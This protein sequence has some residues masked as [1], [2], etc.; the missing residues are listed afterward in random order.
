MIV[1][2]GWERIHVQQFKQ[3]RKVAVFLWLR[4]RQ[5]TVSFIIFAC[6]SPLSLS[7]LLC[8]E[9]KYFISSK[10]MCTLCT[11]IVR[12][13]VERPFSA[14]MFKFVRGFAKYCDIRGR[15]RPLNLWAC[16]LFPLT[17]NIEKQLGIVLQKFPERK[18]FLSR[19]EYCIHPPFPHF[20][21]PMVA[22]R[23]A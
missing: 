6:C 17:Y 3:K 1:F 2:Q 23:G 16:Q 14:I 4:R 7:L 8:L 21:T 22:Y 20:P 10:L 11:Y 18:G 15:W 5:L 19:V 9:I 12:R 13:F